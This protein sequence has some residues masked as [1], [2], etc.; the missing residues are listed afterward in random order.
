M[1]NE[2]FLTPDDDLQAAFDSVQKNGFVHLA[3]GV[4][5]Q[6]VLIRTPGL[7]IIGQGAEYHHRL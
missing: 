5:R 7:T 3:A 4:Y 1:K 2:L 6:K